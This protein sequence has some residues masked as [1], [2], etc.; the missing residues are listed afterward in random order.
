MAAAATTPVRKQ[1]WWPLLWGLAAFLLMPQLPFF[2]VMIPI[3]QPLLLL[4]P[5]I[6]ACS[7]VGWKLGG[8]AA[9]AVIWLAVSVWILLQPAGSPGTPYDQMAR[10]WAVLLA[11]SFGLV[12]LWSV[13]SPFFVR[14]LA[15]VGLATG[16][17]FLIALSSPS[18]IARFQHAAG[19]EF[20]RRVSNTVEKIQQSM[21]TPEWKQLAAKVPSL[22]TWNDESEAAMRSIPDHTASLLPALLALESLAALALGWGIFQRLSPVK[23]GPRLSPLT[24]FRFNDQLV[25]GVA[26]GATL[27]LLPAFAEGRSAGLNLLVF[28]GVLY[29]IRGLGVLAWIARG[30]Y[31]VIVILSLIPQVCIMLG[32]L[33]LALGLGDTWL[34]L[35]RRARAS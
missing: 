27:C 20:T 30:R 11:A 18:G 35:R 33:A 9:L 34:D 6:A 16:V 1:S 15:A 23:I 19:E 31:A 22:D 21:D 3:G 13:T 4:V 5:V 25:W 24:E 26:V 10:G 8:R 12:S 7:V 28:F 2:E 29:L 17:G 32:V 14:A